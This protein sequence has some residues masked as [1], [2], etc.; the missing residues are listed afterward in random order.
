MKKSFAAAAFVCVAT[1]AWCGGSA[2]VPGAPTKVVATAGNAQASVAFTA[3]ANGGS[4]ITKYTVTSSPGSIVATGTASP[5]VVTKLT[6]GVAYSFTVFASNKVGAGLASAPSAA[7]TPATVPGAPTSV[8]A[9]AGSAQASV[10]FTAPASNG[11]SAITKYTVTSSPGAKTAT[12]TASPI[13]VT[14]L[15]NGTAYTFKVVATNSVGN[16]PSSAASAAVTPA[17]TPGAPANVAATAGNAQATVSFTAPANN[18]GSQV[19]KYT[20]TSNP[21]AITASGAKSPIIVAGLT[22]GTAYT[23]TVVA[24]NS[25]GIGP[26]SGASAVV[27]PATVPGA[28]ANVVA[29]AGDKQATVSCTVPPNGGSPITS[30][31][32]VSTS[33]AIT[34]TGTTCSGIVVP[35]LI[36]NVAYTFVVKAT[37]K[38]GTGPASAPSAAV[39]PEPV[40]VISFVSPWAWRVLSAEIVPFVFHGKNFIPSTTLTC[41]PNINILLVQVTGS[42]QIIVYVGFDGHHNG[43]G[44][45]PCNVSNNGVV[46]NTIPIGFYGKKL[47]D[48]FPNG[49]NVCGN[50]LNGDADFFAPKTGAFEK[51]SPGV[52]ALGACGVAA[53]SFTGFW[54]M[55]IEPMDETGEESVNAPIL[56]GGYTDPCIANAAA[57]GFVTI[58]QPTQTDGLSYGSWVGE[59]GSNNYV[60]TAFAGTNPQ[61]LA[62]GVTS[63]KTWAYVFDAGPIVTG[64]PAI[65]KVNL[66]DGMT[67]TSASWPTTGITAGAI[68]GSWMTVFDSLGLGV[69]VSSGDNVANVFS[70]DTLKPVLT[71][72]NGGI[73]A[74]PTGKTPISIIRVK[75]VAIVGNSDGNVGTFTTLDPVTGKV[76]LLPFTVQDMPIGLVPA[77]VAD[78][79]GVDFLVCPQVANPQPGQTKCVPFALPQ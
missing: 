46:S 78:G 10:A 33:G 11:G 76:T 20:A 70:E 71:F 72:G 7:V 8:V 3:P 22:N 65:G 69:I 55:G 44:T 23:F 15:T 24:T 16:G 18:G 52:F 58:V 74:L 13:I 27:T 39:T 77:V 68:G 32:V 28:P 40:P 4:A 56:Q 64:T 61:S 1:F 17:T 41:S 53:D 63:G 21:G 48:V 35:K 50:S 47:C 30:Y 19:T 60:I 2:T 5:I 26:A 67:G 37:N 12:G 29:V 6:N 25:V 43:Y 42:T 31:T 14:G 79:P 49:E 34:A 59:A 54:S 73:I 62:I 9:T 38:V 36:D 75:N 57:N 51:S 45:F 66:T